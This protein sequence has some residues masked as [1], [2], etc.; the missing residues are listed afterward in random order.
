MEAARNA[1]S[2]F[3]ARFASSIIIFAVWSRRT[4]GAASAAIIDSQTMRAAEEPEG[5]GYDAGKKIKGRKRHLLVDTLGLI[6]AVA[7]HSAGIQDRDGGK[8]VFDET[9]PQSRLKLVWADGAY[10][11]QLIDWAKKSSVGRSSS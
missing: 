6:I 8:I 5:T 10:G 1:L 11:G 9:K 7:V 3:S 4:A 2:W